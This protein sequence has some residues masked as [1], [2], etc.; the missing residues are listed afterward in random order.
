MGFYEAPEQHQRRW[1]GANALQH[2]RWIQTFRAKQLRSRIDAG[3]HDFRCEL[4]MKLHGHC[5]G[6]VADDLMRIVS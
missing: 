3:C 5:G 1:C 6:A 4:W 2:G